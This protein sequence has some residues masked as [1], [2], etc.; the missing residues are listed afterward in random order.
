MSDDKP[1]R[2]DDLEH[3]LRSAGARDDQ[4]DRATKTTNQTTTGVGA[5]LRISIDL[6]VAIAVGTG[7]GWVL[8]GWLNTRPWLM[9]VFF[10]LG[11]AAGFRNVFRTAQK[12]DA[13]ARQ[14][15]APGPKQ[16]SEE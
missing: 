10:V 9:L 16:E 12:L 5:A 2:L 8:D 3:R 6:V 11:A 1:P 14:P 13:A 7:I 4:D 15:P